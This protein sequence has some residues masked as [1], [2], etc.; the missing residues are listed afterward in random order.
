MLAGWNC[1]DRIAA[2]GRAVT[3]FVYALV[4]ERERD[5]LRY[6][7]I[8]NNPKRRLGRHL[9][10]SS[11]PRKARWVRRV[12]DSGGEVRIAILDRGLSQD[13]AKLR[14]IAVIAETIAA[15]HDLTNLTAGGD[16]IVG[17]WDDPDF[18]ARMIELRRRRFADPR[19]RARNAAI[20]AHTWRDPATRRVRTI[21]VR[22]ARGSAASRRLTSSISRSAPPSSANKSGFKGVFFSSAAGRWT[23]QIKIDH[24]SKYIGL[25][26]TPED[27]ARAYDKAAFEAWGRDCYL[28]F[29]ADLAA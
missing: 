14:E 17:L 1:F 27:A 8:T 28:N 3:W 10:E 9:T 20:T 19:E 22:T 21:G 29:P 6:I 12:I 7:G 18:R 26:P 5:H 24:R 25:F 23:S 11:G 2:P 4:D 13:E 16:G 15:G